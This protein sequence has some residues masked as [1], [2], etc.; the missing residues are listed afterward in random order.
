[1]TAYE[2]VS[3]LEDYAILAGNYLPIEIECNNASNVPIDLTEL[4]YGCT[5]SLYGDS[6]TLETIIGTLK[7][8]TTNVMVLEITSA[9]TESMSNCCLLYRPFIIDGDKKYKMQG[10]I[11]VFESS[12]IT[13]PS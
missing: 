2:E 13:L 8:N 5:L 3:Q 9:M 6:T 10:K 1:M 11:Y 7:P 4:T 12:T